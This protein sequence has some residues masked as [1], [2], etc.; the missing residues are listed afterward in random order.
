[1]YVIFSG[2]SANCNK[3]VV[4]QKNA[5]S[6]RKVHFPTEKMSF[7]MQKNTLSCRKLRFSGGTC[8]E[9]AGNCRRASGLK[10]QDRRPTFTRIWQRESALPFIIGRTPKGSYP[11]SGRS[12]SS[13]IRLRVPPVALHVSRYTCRS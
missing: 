4:L 5:I 3:W 9:T 10:S 13:C 6:Y 2:W 11:L 8:Q 12:G 1:M 7:F